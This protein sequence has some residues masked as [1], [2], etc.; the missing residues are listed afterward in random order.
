MNSPI[1]ARVMRILGGTLKTMMASSTHLVDG[2]LLQA[3]MLRPANGVPLALPHLPC[4]PVPILWMTPVLGKV[5]LLPR[6]LVLGRVFLVARRML[7]RR[8]C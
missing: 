6:V 5:L 8:P 3:A 1:I 4:L 7:A 2:R